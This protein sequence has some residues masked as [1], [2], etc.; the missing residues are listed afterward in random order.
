MDRQKR[1]K[2]ERD[3]GVITVEKRRW[4]EN[5]KE[6]VKQRRCDKDGGELRK[7]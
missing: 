5:N 2:R 3:G 7:E 6:G 1:R 4:K